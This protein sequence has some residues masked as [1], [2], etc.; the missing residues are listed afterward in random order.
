MTTLPEV[1]S[2]LKGGYVADLVS[3]FQGK[4][5]RIPLGFFEW[6]YIFLLQLFPKEGAEFR[7]IC[8]E[9][10]HWGESFIWGTL[11]FM[12]M[13]EERNGDSSWKLF[14]K[15]SVHFLKCNNKNHL[16]L[17][18]F[19]WLKH[20]LNAYFSWRTHR[21]GETKSRITRNRAQVAVLFTL[22]LTVTMVAAII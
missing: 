21:T 2:T 15:L 3:C 4:E 10:H 16:C 11:M 17:Q 5:Q 14:L 8:G 20:F 7:C 6:E 19:L 9:T 18:S 13:G 22:P 12:V 1:K